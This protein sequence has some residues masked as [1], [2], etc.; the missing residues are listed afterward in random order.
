MI[1]MVV[2]A[3][4]LAVETAQPDPM[5]TTVSDVAFVLDT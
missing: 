2:A 3:G 4:I 5:L 1:T